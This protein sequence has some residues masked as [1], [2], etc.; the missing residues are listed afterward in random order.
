MDIQLPPIPSEIPVQKSMEDYPVNLQKS[1]AI[2]SLIQ[3]NEDLLSRLSVNIR[4][5][6]QSEDRFKK[7]EEDK[8]RLVE[9]ISHL[10]DQIL[11]YRQKDALVLKRNEK[12]NEEFSRVKSKLQIAETQFAEL[13]SDS[14]G[15][16]KHLKSE[17]LK[18]QLQQKRLNK[19]AKKLSQIAK[20]LRLENSKNKSKLSIEVENKKTAHKNLLNATDHIQEKDKNHKSLLEKITD[21]YE[22]EIK[23]LKEKVKIQTKENTHLQ[24]KLEDLE[25][26]FEQNI[27]LKNRLVVI[28]RAAKEHKLSAQKDVNEIQKELAYFRQ[29]AKSKAI[30][31]KNSKAEVNSQKTQFDSIDD[32]NKK[33][34]D[35]VESLQ[36]LWKDSQVELEKKYTQ[37]ESLQALNQKMSSDLLEKKQSFKKVQENYESE[38]YIHQDKIEVLNKGQKES[39][40]ILVKEKVKSEDLIRKMESLIAEIQSGY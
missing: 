16:R 4:R 5:Y 24:S 38:N 28:E 14:Q 33:L 22:F 17:L 26:S 30:E 37:I 40:K 12:S 21:N 27:E 34:K 7:V 9:Q 18:M 29:D 35:Q 6:A 13:N 3:Q 25:M 39:Q 31:L 20:K 1:S 23:Q 8:G 19:Y 11:I 15:R 36:I 2:E 10:K 32:E